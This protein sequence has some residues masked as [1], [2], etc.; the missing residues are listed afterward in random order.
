[1]V[2][3][4]LNE[5]EEERANK[6]IEEHKKMCPRSFKNNNLPTLGDHY[7][8]KFIP[9]GLGNSVSVGCIYCDVEGDITDID[10]W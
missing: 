10:S 7:Y 6:W 5:V 1:M 4:E 9:N 3:F 8:Y 2:K